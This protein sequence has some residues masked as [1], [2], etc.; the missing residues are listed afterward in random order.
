M[1]EAAKV[2]VRNSVARFYFYI[3]PLFIV[4]D[5]IFG[6]N[7]RA[8]ALESMPAYKNLYYA[9]CLLC[10]IFMFIIPGYSAVVALFESSIN[11]LLL[12]LY[13]F[14][15]YIRT[16]TALIDDV[17][18][19]DFKALEES[20]RFEPIMNFAIAAGC[21]IVTFRTSVETIAGAGIDE[22]PSRK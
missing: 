20:F 8:A 6:L 1:H 13:A 17:L 21:M 5:Y 14:L 3:T 12:V 9:F 10:G 15:P 22:P 7:V 2:D 19:A 4:L 18:G 11:I 16:L